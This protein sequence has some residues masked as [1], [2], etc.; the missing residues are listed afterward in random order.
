MTICDRCRNANLQINRITLNDSKVPPI[1]SWDLCKD[2]LRIV[3]DTA[4]MIVKAGV[5]ADIFVV[6]RG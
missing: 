1:N 6:R 2:C 4:V 3:S 5:G